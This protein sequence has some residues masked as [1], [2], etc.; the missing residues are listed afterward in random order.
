[1]SLYRLIATS[2]IISLFSFNLT[3]QSMTPF[4]LGSFSDDGRE[5]VGAVIDNNTVIDITAANV[6]IS[7]GEI[8]VA[9]R[10]I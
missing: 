1:M 9:S 6:S 10:L 8:Y 7:L 2:L 4:K 5:F 3:A